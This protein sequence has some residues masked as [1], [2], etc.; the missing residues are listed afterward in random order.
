MRGL[1]PR[2]VAAVAA[3][4]AEAA[5]GARA[6]GAALAAHPSGRE[7]DVTEEIGSP[8]PNWSPS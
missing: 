1:R 4:A 2:L 6:R 8:D 3:E 5:E 7:P